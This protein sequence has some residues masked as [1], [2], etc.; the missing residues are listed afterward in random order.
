MATVELP[1]NRHTHVPAWYYGASPGSAPGST[2]YLERPKRHPWEIGLL[3]LVIVSSIVL[4][5]VAGAIV[6]SGK[7]SALWLSILATPVVLFLLRGAELRQATGERRQDVAHPV[8]RGLLAR[9]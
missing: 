1:A 3:V 4:Y 6:L 8:S 7:A 9:R 5:T 2:G